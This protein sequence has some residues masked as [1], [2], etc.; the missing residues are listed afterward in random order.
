MSDLGRVLSGAEFNARVV[1][2][3]GKLYKLLFGNLKHRN[4]QY[5]LGLNQLVQ[6][7]NPTGRCSAGGLYFT[8]LNAIHYWMVARRRDT[9]MSK[10]V[11]FIAEVSIR[12]TAQV[13]YESASQFKC[14]ELILLNLRSLDDFVKTCDDP[15]II[16]VY[17]LYGRKVSDQLLRLAITVNPNHLSLLSSPSVAETEAYREHC[18]RNFGVIKVWPVN[19]PSRLR[20]LLGW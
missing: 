10:L 14:D 12:D 18:L 13:Y 20:N 19:R 3:A 7:F 16:D 9:S 8:H 11:P 5:R 6:P 2:Q 4:F 17:V 15:R 1:P